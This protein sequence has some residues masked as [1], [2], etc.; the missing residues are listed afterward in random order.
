MVVIGVAQRKAEAGGRQGER[1]MDAMKQAGDRRL[2]LRRSKVQTVDGRA[3]ARYRSLTGISRA[4]LPL[5]TP[6]EVSLSS[7]HTS[8]GCCCTLP[9]SLSP[10]SEDDRFLFRFGLRT[11]DHRSGVPVSS[12]VAFRARHPPVPTGTAR[13]SGSFFPALSVFPPFLCYTR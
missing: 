2:G 7:A 1:R 11:N 3:R 5:C 4:F 10:V 6:S 13:Y 12:A 9:I 8:V